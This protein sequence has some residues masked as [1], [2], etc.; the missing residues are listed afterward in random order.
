MM[1][2]AEKEKCTQHLQSISKE[3]E[4]LKDI[5]DGSQT[6][7]GSIPLTLTE[8][9]RMLAEWRLNVAICDEFIND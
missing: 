1:E 6:L 3:I 8:V 7:H 5:E 2:D 9:E 4:D